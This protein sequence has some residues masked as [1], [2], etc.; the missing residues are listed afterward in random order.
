MTLVTSLLAA[1]GYGLVVAFTTMPVISIIAVLL[2]TKKTSNGVWLTI[3]YASGLAVV[4]VLA[5]A[6]VSELPWPHL[7]RPSGVFDVLAGILLVIVAGGWWLWS[8]RQPRAQARESDN[9]FMR[10]LASLG[11]TSCAMVG[12][13]FGFH[14]E[15]LVLTI[16]TARTTIDLGWAMTLV[17]LAW[18][19]LV[20]VSTVVGP[21]LMYASSGDRAAERLATLRDWIRVHGPT[22]TVVVLLLAGAALIGLGVWRITA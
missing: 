18:F 21:T 6:G 1:T 22:L 16:A 3:G 20:G 5:V 15:N 11:P 9:R 2:G 13:Q 17:V 4:F 10:W 14:P 8:R 19:C 7:R 12:F